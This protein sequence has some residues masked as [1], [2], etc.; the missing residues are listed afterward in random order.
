[1]LPVLNLFG[2]A[3][4][5]PPLT[6]IGA[7]WLALDL[8]SR[9]AER[10]YGPEK[11]A[12]TWNSAFYG[13]LGALVGARLLFV[14]RNLPAYQNAPLDIIARSVDS[15]DWIGGLLGFLL[16]MGMLLWRR[17]MLSWTTLDTMAPALVL[18]LAGIALATLFSGNAYGQETT[19]PWGIELWGAL[20]HPTQAYELV[21]TLGLFAYLW[22]TRTQS[23]NAGQRI[24][25]AIGGYAAIRLVLEA[26]RAD[27]WILFG[28]MRGVQV[29]SL[30][31][32]LAV[33]LVWRSAAPTVIRDEA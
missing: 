29:M 13:L 8:Y 3:L 12:K 5:L 14:L 31:V 27:S 28:G 24:L 18:F 32:L 17:D 26:F 23:W 33:M 25:V 16:V 20:R 15:L 6:I 1:M 7:V 21:A 30:L 19:L 10:V 11:G 4:P 2:L 9:E 22:Q